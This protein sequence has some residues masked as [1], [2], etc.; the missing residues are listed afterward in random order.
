MTRS[1]AILCVML[2]SMAPWACSAPPRDDG[3]LVDADGA[4]S[5]SAVWAVDLVR[6]LPGRQADYLRGIEAN[7]AGAR[8]LARERGAILSYRALA[9]PPDSSRGWDVILMTEY[10]DS[11]AFADREPLFQDIFASEAFVPLETDVPSSELRE[12]VAGEVVL[13]EVAGSRD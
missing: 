7:W 9:A 12:F 4:G 6:T 13:R 8:R 1:M 2:S 3:P 11:A 5:G 10:T